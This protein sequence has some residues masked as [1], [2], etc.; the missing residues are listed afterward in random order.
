LRTSMT[1]TSRMPNCSP[2]DE[3]RDMCV[4]GMGSLPA[5]HP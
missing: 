4:N 2:T 1:K 5:A 3:F